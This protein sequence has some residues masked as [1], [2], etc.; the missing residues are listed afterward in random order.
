MS[1]EVKKALK[2]NLVDDRKHLLQI[3]NLL[4]IGLLML[5]PR[6][7]HG[8][9]QENEYFFVSTLKWQYVMT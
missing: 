1:T 3:N 8:N 5:F 2:M 6:C 9:L 4:L 7:D